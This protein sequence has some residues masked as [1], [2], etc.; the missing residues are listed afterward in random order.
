MTETL[1]EQAP[2]VDAAV[3]VE[4]A[5]PLSTSVDTPGETGLAVDDQSP[6]GGTG[7][8]V[9]PDDDE[10]FLHTELSEHGVPE[11]DRESAADLAGRVF[12]RLLGAGI[13]EQTA[14]DEAISFAAEVVLARNAEAEYTQ[15][16]ARLDRGQQALDD[17]LETFSLRLGV[18]VDRAEVKQAA[19][20]IFDGWDPADVTRLGGPPRAAL[21]ALYDATMQVAGRDSNAMENLHWKHIQVDQV[22]VRHTQ[23]QQPRDTR[24]RFKSMD[25]LHRAR[26]G[27][28]L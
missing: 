25:Q 18:K 26:F 1:L 28:P 11:A 21:H 22:A 7:T 23:P 13:D 12:E 6:N 14:A 5:E 9:E 17:A 8:P 4:S 10:A 27:L 20:R 16:E 19:T 15:Q 2:P 24:G 3:E